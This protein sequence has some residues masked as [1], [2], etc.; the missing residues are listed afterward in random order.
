MEWKDEKKKY[1]QTR[2]FAGAGCYAC[3]ERGFLHGDP[4]KRRHND[5]QRADNSYRTGFQ[6]GS[7][8]N[9]MEQII[10]CAGLCDLPERVREASMEK[11]QSSERE[12]NFLS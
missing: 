4:G 6:Y 8:Q 12:R 2:R 9:T 10:P 1:I 5:P 7:S 11:N 3:G